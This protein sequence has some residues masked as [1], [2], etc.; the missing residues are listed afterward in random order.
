[1]LAVSHGRLDMVKLLLDAG[2][3]VNIQDEVKNHSRVHVQTVYL[4][5]TQTV[6]TLR[7]AGSHEGGHTAL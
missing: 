5:Y 1:M 2:T 7:A 6:L 4:S 3:D